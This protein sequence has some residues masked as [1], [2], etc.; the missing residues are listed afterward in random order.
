MC[1]IHP[2]QGKNSLF[3]SSIHH[4]KAVIDKV[5]M[6]DSYKICKA[7]EATSCLKAK[8]HTLRSSMVSK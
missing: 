3:E 7:M 1:I 6:A 2:V 8:D 4:G 5:K